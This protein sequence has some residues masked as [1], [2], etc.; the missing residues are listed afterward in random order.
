MEKKKSKWKKKASNNLLNYI[1]TD[2]PQKFIAQVTLNLS[3]PLFLILLNGN[4]NRTGF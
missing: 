1:V 4:D 2:E 3:R